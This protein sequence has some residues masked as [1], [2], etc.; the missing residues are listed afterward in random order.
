MLTN[1]GYENSSLDGQITIDY[2]TD[3]ERTVTFGIRAEDKSK[4]TTYNYSYNIWAEHNATN[5]YLNCFGHV[6]WSPT[7]C[8]TEHIADYKK[9]Y[10]SLSRSVAL[11]KVDFDVKDIL[12]KVMGICKALHFLEYCKQNLF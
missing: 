9:S 4:E 2:S 1:Y 10:L 3:S 11:A 12:I 6:H 5:L 8:G 7:K